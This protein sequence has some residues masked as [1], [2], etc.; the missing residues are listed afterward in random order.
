LKIKGFSK[1]RS[2][3]YS[4]I[5]SQSRFWLESN[6]WFSSGIKN[7]KE[8]EK[9]FNNEKLFSIHPIRWQ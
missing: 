9:K 6:S 3:A 1:I 5:R 7:K 2:T 8:Q 4:A